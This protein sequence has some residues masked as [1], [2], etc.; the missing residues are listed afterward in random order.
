MIQVKFLTT[1]IILIFKNLG[2]RMK[3]ADYHSAEVIEPDN[4]I[5]KSQL[6]TK[7][8]NTPST[9]TKLNLSSLGK[10][11]NNTPEKQIQIDPTKKDHSMEISQRRENNS[12]SG[13]GSNLSLITKKP[14]IPNK[15]NNKIPLLTQDLKKNNLNTTLSPTYQSKG[16][17]INL[18]KAPI[19]D[20]KSIVLK[21]QNVDNNLAKS[22]VSNSTKNSD[23][24]IQIGV[25]L[26]NGKKYPTP[27]LTAKN[28]DNKKAFDFM[29][30]APN[31][32][33]NSNTLII[34]INFSTIK[35][36]N[37]FPF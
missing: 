16:R 7:T 22:F 8:P 34:P 9:P 27:I 30:I 2:I 13:S 5:I 20:S 14:L 15:N 11:I 6:T 21:N 36:S 33:K 28:N 10:N 1:K 17:G 12:G 23:S 31:T 3:D 32:S 29:R 4:Y 35:E 37:C 18:F 26:K 24:M 25:D 19:K